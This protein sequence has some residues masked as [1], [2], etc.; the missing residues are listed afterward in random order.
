MFGIL[1]LI[2]PEENVDKID[3]IFTDAGKSKFNTQ[4]LE[5]TIS[6]Q[7][8]TVNTFVILTFVSKKIILK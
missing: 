1:S 8:I 2:A 4:A 5:P 3:K 6:H 7:D